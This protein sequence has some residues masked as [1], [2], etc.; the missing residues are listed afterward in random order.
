MCSYLV[1]IRYKL[2]SCVVNNHLLEFNTWIQFR[3]LNSKILRLELAIVTQVISTNYLFAAPQEQTIAEFH[4]VG[5]VNASNLLA[6]IFGGIVEGKFG[7]A[8]R[9][10]SGN[11]FQTL[12][13]TVNRF[14]LQ[15]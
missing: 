6:I 1:W 13:N 11:N 14:M 10:F 7:N 15:C 5:F 3:D 8:Q 9:F 2:H 12:Y 4:N